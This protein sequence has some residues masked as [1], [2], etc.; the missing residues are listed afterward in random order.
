MTTGHRSTKPE[1]AQFTAARVDERGR[2]TIP[3][4]V[5]EA[6]DIQEGD[7]CFINFEENYVRVVRGENP[8]EVLSRDA[9]DQDERGETFSF[10]DAMTSLATPEASGTQQADEAVEKSTP[11]D[12]WLAAPAVRQ[13][14]RELIAEEVEKA[15]QRA[16]SAL[17]QQRQS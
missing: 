4:K 9:A 12:L 10:E 3:K 17:Q 16:F 7:T 11:L 8:F 6:L 14:L 5:R 13:H 1:A 15:T 2:I